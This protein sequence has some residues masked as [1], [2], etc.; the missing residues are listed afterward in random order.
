MKKIA[1]Y[2]QHTAPQYRKDLLHLFALLKKYKA[3]VVIN[4]KFLHHLNNE[5]GFALTNTTYRNYRELKKVDFMISIGGD[6]TFLQSA[7][8][9]KALDIPIIGLNT[10]RLGFLSRISTNEIDSA[11]REIFNGN[12]F[13]EPRT[14]LKLETKE[15]LF[16]KNNFALNE[17][18]IHKKDSSSMI[19]IHTYVDGLFLNSYWADGLI[20]STPTGSTAYN[21]SCGGPI[22]MPGSNNFIVTPVAPHNLNVRPLVLSDDSVIELQVEGRSPNFLVGLDSKT[23][24]I[25]SDVKLVIKKNDFKTSL[26]GIKGH[27]YQSTL[28]NKLNWGLDIRN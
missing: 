21:M 13:I 9:I 25:T 17:L 4:S 3:E 24:T 20:V 10:G 11:F 26:I 23:E 15:E 2:G 28:R 14:M 12:Y 22:I 1:I 8:V 6:G 16:G 27:S 7:R 19:I 18:T 5:H